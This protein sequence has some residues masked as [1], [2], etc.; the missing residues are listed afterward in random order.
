MKIAYCILCHKNSRILNETVNY[1]SKDNDVFIHVD[2]KSNINNFNEYKKNAIILKNRIDVR[3]GHISQVKATINLL[4]S[5]NNKNYDYIFLLSGDC[6]P[7]KT[8]RYINKF[9]EKNLPSQYIALDKN[10]KN[11]DDR[12]KYIYNSL[13]YK[14]NCNIVLKVIRKM[15]DKLKIFP[16]NKLYKKLPKLY[17]GTQWFGITGELKFYILDF[18]EKNPEYVKAFENSFCCDEVFFHTIVF[19]SKFRNNIYKPKDNSNICFQALRYIDWST[20]PDFPRILN[21]NDFNNIKKSEC[22]FGR[23]FDENIDILNYRKIFLEE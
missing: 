5:T 20:G 19:N 11:L 14:K 2:K 22:L 21:E 9:L 15:Q 23:K 13:Y 6:L 3:W 4:K 17:K 16:R 1:L 12:V 18:I 7:L 8:N 10:F